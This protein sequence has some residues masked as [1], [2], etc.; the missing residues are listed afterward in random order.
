MKRRSALRALLFAAGLFIP[1]CAQSQQTAQESGAT[2]SSQAAASKNLQPVKL[3]LVSYGVAKPLYSKII[4]AFQ[5]EWKAKTG[6][7][8][9]F[10]ESYGASGAQTRAVLGGLEAD[11]LAQNQQSNV[12]P[13]V[14]K[15]F[16]N[17]NW[18]ERLPNQASPASTVMVLVTRPGNPKKIQDWSDLA[19][20]GISI[21]AI[22]PQTS[23]NAHWG[24]LASY[25]S[26]LKAQGEQ[27]AQDFLYDFA[28][29]I[30]TLVSIGR[31]ATD[32]FVRNQIGDVLVTFENE[33][34]FT[35]EAI[36][37]DYPYVVPA[38][39]IRVNFPTTVID[40]T[41]NA[42]DTR[43]I[44]EAFTEFLF[45]PTAQ[46][47]FAQAGYRP[48]DEQVFQRY[49]EQYK[50]VETLYTVADFGGWDAVHQKL[51]ADGALFDAAQAARSQ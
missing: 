13:L 43:E 39:N 5:V 37:E 49:A 22:N 25:G 42:R 29:N 36:P 21:V 44:A 7:D 1:A 32:A 38:S 48:I 41:V 18:S 24:I 35:N 28:N 16:V 4:P 19:R 10:K 45:T 47:F 27:A 3:T 34:L 50:P 33:I 8:V 46:D 17:A 2:E 12:E 26:V 6:Q 40:R 51:F 9:T 31:E 20:E 15:G 23:G 11:I 30:K 14:E